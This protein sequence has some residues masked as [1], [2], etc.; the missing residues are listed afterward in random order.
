MKTS[1]SSPAARAVR[2]LI[3]FILAVFAGL[4]LTA[5][6]GGDAEARPYKVGSITVRFVGTANVNEQVVRANMQAREGA[7]LDDTMIDRDI[8]SL[9]RTGLF[10]FI[11]VKREVLPARVI[12]LV[13]EV[14]PKYRVLAIRYEGNERVKNQEPTRPRARPVAVF[15]MLWCNTSATIW[16]RVAP[17]APRMPISRVRCVT[18][19][20]STPY[21]PMAASSKA[22]PENTA[23]RSTMPRRRSSILSMPSCNEPVA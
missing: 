1:L 17:S 14:T 7:E 2:Y 5:Q 16:A 9:Y 10:E 22:R 19:Y 4:R 13:V 20:A 8:Q 23:S 21:R 6:V 15:Q 3:V 11:E 18:S 12:N